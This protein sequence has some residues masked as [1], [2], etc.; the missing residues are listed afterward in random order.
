M[1]KQFIKG[2]LIGIAAFLLG[3]VVIALLVMKLGSVPVNADQQPTALEARLLGLAVH[4]SVARRAQQ[5]PNPVLST[6]GGLTTGAEIY[7]HMCAKCHGQPNAGPSI[8]G[9]SFYP[10]APQLTSHPPQYTEA[11]IF[12]IVKHGIRNT[13]MPAWG[14]Q[15][16]DEDI[17][18]VVAFLKR[19]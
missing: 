3:A 15:L 1:K 4:A 7:T 6:E 14:R 18:Q 2:A 16:S 8:Y 9:A 12:W 10:P 19:L 5:Q 13:A 17:W 11:E